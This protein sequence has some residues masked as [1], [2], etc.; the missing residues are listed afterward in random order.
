MTLLPLPP[1]QRQT[2]FGIGFAHIWWVSVIIRASRKTYCAPIRPV[3]TRARSTQ[4]TGKSEPTAFTTNCQ[5]KP[6]LA[7]NGPALRTVKRRRTFTANVP[8]ASPHY[9][10]KSQSQP[11]CSAAEAPV[12]RQS[13]SGFGLARLACSP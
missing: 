9:Y 5:S 13:R 3:C 7:G 11:A 4:R 8:V 12:R 6:I 1:A 2:L 10:Y